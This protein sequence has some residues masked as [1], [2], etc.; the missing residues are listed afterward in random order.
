M[1]AGWTWYDMAGMQHEH[2]PYP[3]WS[4]PELARHARH[5]AD[6]LA[7]RRAEFVGD[8]ATAVVSVMSKQGNKVMNSHVDNL[9]GRAQ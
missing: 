1:D 7:E 9:L 5:A 2:L 6:Y 4:L 3:G 8:V